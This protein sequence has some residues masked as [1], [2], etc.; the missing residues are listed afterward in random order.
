MAIKTIQNELDA[1]AKNKEKL[2]L[3][4]KKILEREKRFKRKCVNELINQVGKLGIPFSDVHIMIGA[5]AL[6]QE[7]NRLQEANAKGL[8]LANE[9]QSKQTPVISNQTDDETKDVEES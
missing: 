3:E 6:I 1:I 2:A 7:E 8:Q 9:T 5:I 4:Q